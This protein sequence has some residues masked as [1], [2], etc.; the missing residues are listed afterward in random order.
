MKIK[1][2]E[3]IINHFIDG[4]K[5]DF[6]I[7]VENE[8]FIFDS[9]S[10]KRCNYNQ[11]ESV[12]NFLHEKF[13][14]EKVKEQNYLIGL[15]NNDK[16]VTLEPGNQ[17]ELAGAKLKNIHEVCSE[18]FQF[19]DQLVSACKRLNLELLSIGFDPRSKLSE[20]PS[21]PKKRYNIMTKE[22]PKNGK[23]SLEM[24]YQT[25]GT[26]INLDYSDEIDFTEKFKLISYLTPLSIALFAN[27]SIK[28]N[29][30][31]KYLSYRSVVWQNTSRG[32]LP[33]IFLEDMDFEKYADFCLNFPL[34]FIVKDDEYLTPDNFTFKDFVENKIKKIDNKSP[35]TKDLEN[36][37]STIFT[38]VRLKKYLEIRS[39]DACEWDCHC[40][41]PAFYTG[42]IYGNKYE[43]LDI[44]K[45]WKADD[46]LNAYYEAPKKG[47][48]TEINGK[49][50]LDWSKIFLNICKS[51][52]DIRNEI[53]SKGNNEIVYLKN[54]ENIL[55]EEK[56]KAEKS[57]KIA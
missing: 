32:G 8:K 26:Q 31:T 43:A 38:D 35:T 22:M 47:L 56:T 53:N 1:N 20:V 45:N 34:L 2:K 41:S 17:I 27:S 28:E 40:A 18:S 4:N 54:I 23:L 39:I 29:T 5:K 21:N 15:K 57:I 13:K 25:A 19:Q 48:S 14:W 7:G 52:L 55:S 16:Q 49:K 50:I 9:N 46:V 6:F 44:I 51:G 12:L 42:L 36:H 30:F 3:D 33:K 10:K 37:L 24:M 11:V